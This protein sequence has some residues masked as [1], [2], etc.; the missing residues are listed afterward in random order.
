LRGSDHHWHRRR[1]LKLFGQ[2]AAK[3]PTAEATPTRAEH[4]QIRTLFRRYLR[5]QLCTIAEL[6][7]DLRAAG[8]SCLIRDLLDSTICVHLQLRGQAVRVAGPTGQRVNEHKA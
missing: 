6:D 4:D 7:P 2:R 8:D 5:E 1:C 3:V